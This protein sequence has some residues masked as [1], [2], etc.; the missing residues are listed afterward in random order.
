MIKTLIGKNDY[1]FLINDGCKELETQSSKV[2]PNIKMPS[3]LAF[4]N[5]ILIVFPNK[6]LI[7]N[8]YLPER[9]K[10]K[11]RHRLNIYKSHLK[12]KLLDGYD[13]LKDENDVYYKTDTHINLKGSYIVYK[14][15]IEKVN[16]LFNLNLIVE[17]IN[18]EVKTCILKDLCRGV[19][20]LTWETNLG[21]QVLNDITD[22]YYYSND[23]LDFY[24]RYIIK[25][26]NSI[27]FLDYKLN[28]N[29]LV[30]ENQNASW[31]II[32]KYIIYKKN[33]HCKH[34]VLIFYDSF[35]LSTLPLY[36]NLFGEV[37]LIK[38]IYSNDLIKLI[39]P[40]YVFEFRVERF[41]F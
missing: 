23:M 22:T 28:D 34:I 13:Y 33:E 25:N 2:I 14:K 20:D 41:L 6:S 17:I 37:Y 7:Q 19:G 5:Y 24:T 9:Y 36:L 15:F 32:S 18:I 11:Y 8:H 4:S 3:H 21:N 29:T 35:L 39:N 38:S 27:K 16:E 40:K 10:G 26:E 31:D 12:E 30:L 1:L